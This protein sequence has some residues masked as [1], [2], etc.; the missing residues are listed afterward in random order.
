MS[1]GIQELTALLVVA[2]VVGFALYRR[3]RRTRDAA[4]GCSDCAAAP[5]DKAGEKTVHIF[6]RRD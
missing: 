3:W 5:D 2:I 6:R 4:A 1:I